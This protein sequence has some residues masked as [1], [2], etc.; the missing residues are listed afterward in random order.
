MRN[1]SAS[2]TAWRSW[3]SGCRL[4]LAFSWFAKAYAIV[5]SSRSTPLRAEAPKPSFL[6]LAGE[7]DTWSEFVAIYA[8]Q[9]ATL[10][11]GD[12]KLA[13][14]R[15]LGQWSQHVAPAR[16]GARLPGSKLARASGAG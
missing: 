8:R 11:D 5:R 13:R 12:A 4:P 9:V 6:R 14:L 15:L 1:V 3:S 10:E 2:C 7:A 16:R